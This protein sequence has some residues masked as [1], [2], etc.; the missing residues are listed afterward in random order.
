MQNAPPRESSNCVPPNVFIKLFGER[1]HRLG[2]QKCIFV[3]MVRVRV[4][5]NERRVANGGDD[6]LSSQ[7]MPLRTYLGVSV[8]LVVYILGNPGTDL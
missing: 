1:A 7:S 8:Y 6:A 3:R 5:D 4:R 2:C